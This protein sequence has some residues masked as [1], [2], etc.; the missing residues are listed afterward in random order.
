MLHF[1]AYYSNWNTHQ[2]DIS[3]Y[4]S[5]ESFPSN[6]EGDLIEV[7]FLGTIAHEDGTE[8]V[9]KIINASSFGDYGFIKNI[10]DI[11]RALF[12]KYSPDHIFKNRDEFHL[13]IAK[14]AIELSVNISKNG[15]IILADNSKSLGSRIEL[16]AW[17]SFS[18]ILLDSFQTHYE[19]S[20]MLDGSN[21]EKS[22]VFG[23]FDEYFTSEVFI[24]NL[25]GNY[26]IKSA[27]IED[28]QRYEIIYAS[29]ASLDRLQADHPSISL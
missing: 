9:S 13:A 27:S 2:L 20:N 23:F 29:K 5:G 24:N 10:P 26:G 1:N 18:N 16:S 21:F 15:Y 22:L 4:W 8:K 25:Q 6:I 19:S 11:H 28:F 17:E 3:T 14:V 7:K 12:S